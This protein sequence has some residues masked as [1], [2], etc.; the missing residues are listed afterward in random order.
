MPSSASGERYSS[1]D[2]MAGPTLLN[3]WPLVGQPDVGLSSSG[4]SGL[5]GGAGSRGRSYGT[6]SVIHCAVRDVILLLLFQFGDALFRGG[7]LV[8]E[9]DDA[10]GRGERHVLIE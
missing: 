3:S 7:E 10:D 9:A 2:A 6:R 4:S 1:G 5:M 8:F